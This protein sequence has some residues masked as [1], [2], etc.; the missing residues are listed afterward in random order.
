MKKTKILFM[1]N[2]MNI[3]GAEKSLSSLLNLFDYE[4]YEVYLQM[5]NRGGDF[6]EILPSEV[7]ILPQLPYFEFCSQPLVKQVVSGKV[8]FLKARLL[9][10][11]RLKRNI[12][13]GSPLHPAQAFW[14]GAEAAFDT[15]PGEYDVAIAWG[16]GT[17]TH[18]VAKKVNARKKIAWVNV[19]YEDAGYN[20][21]FDRCIYGR[22]DRIVC[23]SQ[24]L[25]E[26]FLNVFPAYA[27]KLITIYDINNENLIK[28][29]ASEFVEMPR[30]HGT[31]ITTAGRLAKQK[32][33]DIAIDAARI[34]KGRG[35]DFTWIACG[36]GPERQMLESRIAQYGLEDDFIL[37]GSKA[38]PYPYMKAADVY[39]Q[40]SRFEGYCLTLTEARI[41][42]RPCVATRFDVVYDQM[43]DGENGLVV[44][45]TPEAV[46]EG[47]LR[48]MTD[49][50]L[51]ERCVANL[52]REKIGNTEEIEKLYSILES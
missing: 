16:Q 7:N 27:E 13:A 39:V 1:I 34:L 15:L 28:K 46:A 19:N 36:D 2:S 44:D 29:M 33:Y 37:V 23:V 45:M 10:H 47:V 17:P 42:N 21:D 4:R 5:I 50:E 38:N 52:A 9:V 24:K 22:Y 11:N 8:S 3:G 49:T 40:T 14:A 32:G 41:L 26:I 48:M 51:R 31:I 6:E 43:V 35:I 18:F 20:R 25:K 12:R 30:L